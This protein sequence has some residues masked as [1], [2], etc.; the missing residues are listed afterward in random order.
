MS[1]LE[2]SASA[3]P[4][5]AV[6]Q[7][8]FDQLKLR[9]YVGLA[10]FVLPV[11]TLVM[12]STPLSSIS[13]SYYSDAR[14]YFVGILFSLGTLLWAYNG[15]TSSLPNPEEESGIR[16][17]VRKILRVKDR[18]GEQSIVSTVG[19]AAAVVAALCPTAC[20]GC[21]TNLISVIH[22]LAAAILFSA[23]VYVCL[24]VF[25]DSAIA[26]A[27][28]NK[29]MRRSDEKQLRRARFY[30]A[31][32]FGIIA[33]MLGA[34]GAQLIIPSSAEATWGTT[35]WAETI[36]LLLFSTAWMVGSRMIG[37]FADPDETLKPTQ[38]PPQE[39]TAQASA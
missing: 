13:A 2:G 16:P 12:A 22:Y 14:D 37:W 4:S 10:A 32:G 35:F 23:T 38:P 8:E 3:T 30:R 11:A 39:Q 33:C 1:T 5:E 36:A 17:I 19:G 7:E 9:A 6:K 21:E 20:N 34:G 29:K 28:E 31:C 27:K 26:K 15:H 25:R 24:F 18:Q